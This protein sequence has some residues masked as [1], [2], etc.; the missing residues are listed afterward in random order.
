MRKWSRAFA[1]AT[2]A[3]LSQ[4]LCS[5]IIEFGLENKVESAS[6]PRVLRDARRY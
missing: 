3:Y 5:P 4:E 6:P 1:P 2:P